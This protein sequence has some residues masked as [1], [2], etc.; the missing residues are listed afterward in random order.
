MKKENLPDI[1]AS[2]DNE[3]KNIDEAKLNNAVQQ[4]SSIAGDAV[5]NTIKEM[6]AN[7]EK[8]TFGGLLS[9]SLKKTIS[10]IKKIEL[11]SATE[12]VKKID[13]GNTRNGND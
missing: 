12:E 7:G 2:A 6:T 5:A 11:G 13:D 3:L 10:N 1:P 8:V 4:I 9:R